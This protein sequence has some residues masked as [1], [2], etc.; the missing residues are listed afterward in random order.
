MYDNIIMDTTPYI[1][2]A[3]GRSG[4]PTETNGRCAVLLPPVP[5]LSSVILCFVF[6]ADNPIQDYYEHFD[7][8]DLTPV[9]IYNIPLLLSFV[10]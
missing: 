3:H 2:V 5:G 4:V 8:P 6:D 1:A 9:Q 10:G 7:D